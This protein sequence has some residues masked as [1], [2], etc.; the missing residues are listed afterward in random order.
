MKIPTL[1]LQ[2]KKHFLLSPDLCYSISRYLS[3][4]CW[5]LKMLVRDVFFCFS[6]PTPSSSTSSSSTA[7]YY[8]S[9]QSY[10]YATLPPPPPP[11][12]PP[13]CPPPPLSFPRFL[14]QCNICGIL[15]LQISQR[16]ISPNLLTLSLLINLFY[17]CL[18][19]FCVY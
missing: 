15:N 4:V 9:V 12:P 16:F 7:Y 6:P 1:L 5:Q 10:F 8:S 11:P 13:I 3:S 2:A 18:G 14:I 17:M 19:T